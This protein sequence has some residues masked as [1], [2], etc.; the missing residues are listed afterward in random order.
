MAQFPPVTSRVIEIENALAAALKCGGSFEVV[1]HDGER[2]LQPIL[3]GHVMPDA[4]SSIPLLSLDLVARELE[5]LL[6]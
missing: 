3:V 5:R 1:T 2:F 4:I 6:S